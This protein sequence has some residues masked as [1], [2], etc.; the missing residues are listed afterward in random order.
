VSLPKGLEL[1]AATLMLAALFVTW[2]GIAVVVVPALPL[3][4]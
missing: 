1:F 2:D 4:Q 3:M